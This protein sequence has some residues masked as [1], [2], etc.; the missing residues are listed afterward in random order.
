MPLAAVLAD[1]AMANLIVTFT[2]LLIAGLCSKLPNV[3]RGAWIPT[4]PT[5]PILVKL[6]NDCVM[7]KTILIPWLVL[8]AV[9]LLA[10]NYGLMVF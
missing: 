1:C 2:S 3:P 9:W 7:P 10:L 4:M 8:E 6:L 5:R